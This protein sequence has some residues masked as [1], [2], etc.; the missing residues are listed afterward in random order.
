MGNVTGKDIP[1]QSREDGL[2]KRFLEGEKGKS[3][4]NPNGDID[5]VKKSI[6]ISTFASINYGIDYPSESMWRVYIC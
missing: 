1:W 6:M 2:Y 3:L 5:T 4:R